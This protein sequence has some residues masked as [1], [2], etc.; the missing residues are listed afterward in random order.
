MGNLVQRAPQQARF[1]LFSLNTRILEV[2]IHKKAEPGRNNGQSPTGKGEV[3]F[4]DVADMA[5]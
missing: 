4:S 1:Y 3:I 2:I 5:R